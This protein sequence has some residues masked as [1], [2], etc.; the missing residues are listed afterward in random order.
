MGGQ[1]TSGTSVRVSDASEGV[2]DLQKRCDEV[3]AIAK[4]LCCRS[5]FALQEVSAGSEGLVHHPTL[6]C[7]D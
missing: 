6:Y 3:N 4:G 2:G 5:S 1:C 7:I